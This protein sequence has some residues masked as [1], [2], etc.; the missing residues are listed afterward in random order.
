MNPIKL[1]TKQYKD[2]KWVDVNLEITKSHIK[3]EKRQI[4]I[5]AIRD[6]EL[7]DIDG[8]K[9]IQIKLDN[10]N[11]NL[12]FPPKLQLQVFKYLAFNLKSDKFM[13][14]F[15][16]P[17]TRGGVVVRNSKWEKGYMSV[18]DGAVWFLSPQKQIRI[19]LSNL[20]SV[21]RDVRTV[22][23]KQRNVLVVGHVEGN[24]VL[25]SLLLCPET[26]LEMLQKYLL[27]LIEEHG[28]SEGLEEMEEQ[29]ATL[30]YTGLDSVSVEQM[31]GL[32]TEELNKYYDRL[33]ELGLAKVVKIRKELELTPKGVALVSRVQKVKKIM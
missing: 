28:N 32:S 15:L 6:L 21:E 11:L 1:L 22:A 29:I 20:G 12:L 24:E 16:S 4:E 8:K 10:E 9:V 23:G 30:I 25:T 27:K 13:V 5:K 7:K 18:T 33:V 3:I 31:L 26:T 17:A 14:Y 2:E 19:S